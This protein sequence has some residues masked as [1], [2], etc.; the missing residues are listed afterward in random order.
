MTTTNLPVR[1]SWTNDAATAVLPGIGKSPAMAISGERGS[2]GDAGW[3]VITC[4]DEAA[5]RS[6]MARYPQAR[7]PCWSRIEVAS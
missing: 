6:L 4:K 1:L 7:M 3:T 2:W 5:M